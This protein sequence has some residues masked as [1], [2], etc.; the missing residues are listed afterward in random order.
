[1][2]RES[3]WSI[4]WSGWAVLA[5]VALAVGKALAAPEVTAGQVAVLRDSLPGTD[6]TTTEAV[7]AALRREGFDVVFLAA[8]QVCDPKT[9]SAERFFLYV[10]PSPQCYP[11]DGAEALGSY[12]KT[13]GNLLVLGTPLSEPLWKLDDQWL[14]RAGVREVIAHVKSDGIVYDFDDGRRP[15]EWTRSNRRSTHCVAEVVPGGVDGSAGCLQVTMD[16]QAGQPDGWGGPL[17][18][19]ATPATGGLLSF[20]AKGDD[21]TPQVNVRLFEGPRASRPR[22]R[23]RLAHQRMEALRAPGRG[24]PRAGQGGSVSGQAGEL[25]TCEQSDHARRGR[26]PAHV[27]GRPDRHCTESAGRIGRSGPD[28][29]ADSGNDIAQ[30][31]DLSAEGHRGDRRRAGPGDR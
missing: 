6:P 31:Q 19:N 20:W 26:R 29:V 13:Q 10:I 12:L 30:L 25:R 2:L 1:M 3:K 5:F 18:P 27:L 28:T 14:D 16:Y 8:E 15:A 17:D 11:A 23:R 21:R 9:L 22:H 24:F 7:A 4:H